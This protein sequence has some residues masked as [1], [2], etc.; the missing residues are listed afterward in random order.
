VK[1]KRVVDQHSLL[2]SNIFK[3]FKTKRG[4]IVFDFSFN[5]IRTFFPNNKINGNYDKEFLLIINSTFTNK[6]INQN[7]LIR[8]F[9][10]MIRP[11]FLNEDFYYDKLVKSYKVLKYL[12]TLNLFNR[13]VIKLETPNDFL[14]DFFTENPLLDSVEKRALFLEGLLVGKLLAIQYAERKNKPFLKR[15]NGLKIDGKIAQR[16]FTEAINKLEEYD[17]NYY[18]EL[19]KA[20]AE[21][22]LKS[23]LNKYSVDE[24]SYYFTLGMTLTDKIL[25]SKSNTG[26]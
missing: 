13:K 9:L 26:E 18:K 25:P 22:L 5:F 3:E 6:I 14:K 1:A 4:E 2:K 16:I 12:D 24:L 15:L 10:E 20:I 23:E 21:Y 8:R 11:D 17:K 19:E 7:L